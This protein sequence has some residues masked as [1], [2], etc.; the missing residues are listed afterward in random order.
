[1]AEQEFLGVNEHPAKILDGLPE[2]FGRGQVLGGRRQLGRAR[3]P[4]KGDGIELFRYLFGRSAALGQS[5]HSA[6]IVP[7]LAVDCRPAD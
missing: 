1:M 2:I 7:E 3:I 6:V 5:S 4:A